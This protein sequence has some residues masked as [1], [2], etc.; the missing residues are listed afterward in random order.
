[1]HACSGGRWV[2]ALALRIDVRPGPEGGMIR[3]VDGVLPPHVAEWN[4]RE[5][6][7]TPMELDW[8]FLM[9]DDG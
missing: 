5:R 7:L 8:H 9:V 4:A 1:M 6:E 2:E 3:R